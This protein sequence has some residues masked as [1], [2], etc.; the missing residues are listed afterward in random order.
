L[1]TL[2][3][4]AKEAGVSVMTVSNVVNENLNKV[5]KEN[6][7]RIRSII[8]KR[9]YIPDF[10]ARSL[11]RG[12]SQIIAIMLRS[13]HGENSLVSPH[14]AALI[15]AI[16]KKVQSLGYYAM[17]NMV[18][19]QEDI[20][21][22]LHNWNVD[23]AVF[24]GMFDNEIKQI[25]NENKAPMVFIDSYCDVRQISNVGIDDYKGGALAA[26]HLINKGHIKIGFVSPSTQHNGVIYQRMQ[27]FTNSLLENG[28]EL[29]SERHFLLESD[30][31]EDS[32]LELAR[33]IINSKQEIT[34]LFAASDQI[35]AYIVQGLRMH[36]RRVPEDV[37]VV[38]FDD[39]MLSTQI[40]PR[41][42]TIGQNLELKGHIAVDILFRLMK[43]S[44]MAAESR[45]LDVTLVERESVADIND[46]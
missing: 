28:I 4:I 44:E 18:E 29:T 8:K 38:G 39:M 13:V 35:A 32:I 3:D 40:T 10:S 16:I 19:T 1:I 6:V 12:T 31:D 34:A 41:L 26:Q 30:V 5:S 46:R 20:S 42:T 45:I 9:G 7:K 14:N 22:S 24:L 25:H 27:G 33:C 2:K 43:E 23:G 36:G 21:N 17:V 11:V 37:S 15:G